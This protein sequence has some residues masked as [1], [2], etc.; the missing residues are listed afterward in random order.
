MG[1]AV[2]AQAA[3]GRCGENHTTP[4]A[5]AYCVLKDIPIINDELHILGIVEKRQAPRGDGAPEW[6]R[7]PR[8]VGRSAAYPSMEGQSMR[9]QISSARRT[10]CSLRHSGRL[11]LSIGSERLGDLGLAWALQSGIL[12]VDAS[13]GSAEPCLLACL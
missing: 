4:R 5:R 13:R 7:K 9:G 12:R 11:S 2:S 1:P 10:G 8:G 3:M 6:P